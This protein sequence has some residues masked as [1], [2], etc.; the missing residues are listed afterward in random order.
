MYSYPSISLMR[1]E[2]PP[3]LRM[4]LALLFPWLSTSDYDVQAGST[5]YNCFNIDDYGYLVYISVNDNS[6]TDPSCPPISKDGLSLNLTLGVVHNLASMAFTIRNP[7]NAP[8]PVGVAVSFDAFW[9]TD[10]A[11]INAFG[12]D[13]HRLWSLP[14]LPHWRRCPLHHF[15]SAG[16]TGRDR[17]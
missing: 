15:Y 7:T 1:M 3:W 13:L 9:R 16:R 17:H 14:G 12:N 2:S 5:S 10:Y 11:A 6:A 4:L 8:A